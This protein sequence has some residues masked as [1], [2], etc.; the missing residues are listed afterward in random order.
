VLTLI[1]KAQAQVEQERLAEKE[2]RWRKAEFTLEDFLSQ[3]E[4]IRRM[5]PLE[6]LVGLLPGAAR[7]WTGSAGQK[8]PVDE[9]SLKR[10][11]AIIQSMTREERRNPALIDGSRRRRIARG[12][13]TTV[14]EV[15]QLLKQYEQTRQLLR[16][17][18]SWG[19]KVPRGKG[20]PLLPLFSDRERR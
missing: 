20:F 6:E 16:Q 15:N 13:G 11:T 7:P 18:G 4:A 9:R 17:L 3:L 5:G 12:S 8:A 14:Q 10:L 1:E 2:E 19:K